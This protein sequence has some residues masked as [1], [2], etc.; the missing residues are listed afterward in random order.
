MS[1]TRASE[2]N[3]GIETLCASAHT[4]IGALLT[5]LDAAAGDH[6]GLAHQL[7]LS[8]EG[9]AA[10]AARQAFQDAAAG[11]SGAGG[12]A[13]CKRAR[14]AVAAP[15]GGGGPLRLLLALPLNLLVDTAVEFVGAKELSRLEVAVPDSSL[16]N[17]LPQRPNISKK[18]NSNYS[19]TRQLS[20]KSISRNMSSQ[21]LIKRWHT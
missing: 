11:A 6:S 10:L 15:P 21:E 13:A 12:E 20:L 18:T 16:T 14:V 5:A 9:C 1:A 3:Q 8:L 17:L 19:K 4:A 2:P 7:A